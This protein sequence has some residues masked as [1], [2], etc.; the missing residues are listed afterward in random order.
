MVDVPPPLLKSLTTSRSPGRWN[1]V[2]PL[3]V[4]PL[5][6]LTLF[7]PSPIPFCR[8]QKPCGASPLLSSRSEPKKMMSQV[9]ALPL[10]QFP[11]VEPVDWIEYRA[12]NAWRRSSLS[13][14]LP[15]LSAHAHWFISY[16]SFEPPP[17]K[18]VAFRR[19][20]PSP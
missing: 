2:P 11:V 12:A 4:N 1:T 9:A 6:P 14:V 3:L 17:V 19:S 10:G 20:Q 8:N 16:G 15:L 5:P 13:N 7:V 18:N